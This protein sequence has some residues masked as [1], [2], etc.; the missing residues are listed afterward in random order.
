MRRILVACVGN[1]IRRDDGFGPEVARRLAEVALPAGVEVA[2]FGIAGLALVQRLMDGY[3]GLIIVDAIAADGA[4]PGSLVEADPVADDLGHRSWTDIQAALGDIHETTPRRVL[5]LAK[6]VGCLPSSVR[7]LGCRPLD[8]DPGL[9][10]T[11]CVAAAVDTALARI[12]ATVA[13]WR[14]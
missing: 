9:T 2:E 4:A 13:A 11:P 7:I 3:D 10:L 6:S 1:A 14:G 8:V 5:A 12:Q